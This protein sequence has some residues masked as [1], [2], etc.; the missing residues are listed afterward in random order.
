MQLKN[1]LTE[2]EEKKHQ[3]SE[4]H[5]Q[6]KLVNSLRRIK[7]L[8]NFYKYRERNDR[9]KSKLSSNTLGP[10]VIDRQGKSLSYST[11]MNNMGL[12]KKNICTQTDAGMY[13]HISM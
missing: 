4:L 5:H 1:A 12:L 10:L 13:M 11:S 9:L 2:L 7:I 6:L 8:S 3:T